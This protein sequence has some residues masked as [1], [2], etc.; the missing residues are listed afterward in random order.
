MESAIEQ[1]ILDN[2]TIME[3][4]TINER[5]S[6]LLDESDKIYEKLKETLSPEQAELLDKLILN[7]M[8]M[9]AEASERYLIHGFKTAVKLMVEC[10]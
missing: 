1:L 5:Y 7:H 2:C 8:S 6:N 10:L 4:I 9:E 3:H